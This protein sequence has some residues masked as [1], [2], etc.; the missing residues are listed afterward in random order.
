[1]IRRFT[2]DR[3]GDVWAFIAVAMVFIGIPLASLTIDVVRGMYVR[4]HLQIATDAAC[5]AA[6]DALD[7]AAFQAGGVRRIDTS[8][9]RAQAHSVFYATLGDA[10]KVGYTPALSISFPSATVARCVASA[11]INRL[12]PL[13]PP[14]TASV[15]TTSEMRVILEP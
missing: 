5:Q 13:T 10:G 14:M 15:A 11:S 12:V 9:G 8:R 2:R 1:M 7:A 6:A 4:T 3:R